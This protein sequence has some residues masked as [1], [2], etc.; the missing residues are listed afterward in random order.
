MT[1]SA[2]FTTCCVKL[3][4]WDITLIHQ[5][6]HHDVR[7]P[8]RSVCPVK[9]PTIIT[10]KQ[11][12]LHFGWKEELKRSSHFLVR[13]A[14]SCQDPTPFFDQLN[15]VYPIQNSQIP[16]SLR[17]QKLKFEASQVGEE[18]YFLVSPA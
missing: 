7:V 14:Q 5:R 17:L 9:I 11:E 2:T 6:N 1:E 4:H 13:P 18:S 8:P 10:R 16:R 3:N 12:A 15:I